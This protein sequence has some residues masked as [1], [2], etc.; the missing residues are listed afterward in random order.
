MM[1]WQYVRVIRS[2]RMQN[3]ASGNPKWKVKFQDQRG[4]TRELLTETDS[5][6]AFNVSE[7][8]R[9]ARVVV[10]NQRIARYEPMGGAA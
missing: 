3:T 8:D 2:R 5:Q 4:D 1:N 7:N 6:D 10:V 9:S